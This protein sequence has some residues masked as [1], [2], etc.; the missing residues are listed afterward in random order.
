VGANVM[1]LIAA[2][3]RLEGAISPF[4]G[5]LAGWLFGG[6]SPSP[7]RKLWLKLQ[8]A[9]LDAEAR[10]EGRARRQRAEHSHLRVIEGGRH[11]EDPERSDKRGPDGRWLN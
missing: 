1:Y 3:Q 9:R 8:L 2:A 6:G 7:A 11:E 10:R 5:M 4:G